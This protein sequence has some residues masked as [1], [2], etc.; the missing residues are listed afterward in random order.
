M[1]DI[2]PYPS[3]S[4]YPSPVQWNSKRR[5][6]LQYQVEII[7][8]WELQFSA[9]LYVGAMMV[10]EYVPLLGGL[11][12][13][14]LPVCAFSGVASAVAYFAS[15]HVTSWLCGSGLSTNLLSCNVFMSLIHGKVMPF[16]CVEKN[17]GSLQVYQEQVFE[18]AT[19]WLTDI[20]RCGFFVYTPKAMHGSKSNWPEKIALAYQ[21]PS[22]IMDKVKHVFKLCIGFEGIDLAIPSNRAYLSA[23]DAFRYADSEEQALF[24]CK[25]Q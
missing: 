7:C 4:A 6:V 17:V 20:A 24:A 8:F 23:R 13:P 12:K 19:A 15:E 18:A 16:I 1:A 3:Q 21:N 14:L 22:E 11:V 10:N 25:M 9:A 5:Q 2:H